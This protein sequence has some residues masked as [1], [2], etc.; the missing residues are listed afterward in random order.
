M[1]SGVISSKTHYEFD[2]DKDDRPTN[3]RNDFDA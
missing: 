1:P 3:E 2:D